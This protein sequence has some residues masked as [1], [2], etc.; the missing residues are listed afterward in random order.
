MPDGVFQCI[1]THPHLKFSCE[2]V[3]T[4]ARNRAPASHITRTN[5]PTRSRDGT[6]NKCLQSAA[7]KRWKRQDTKS[8]AHVCTLH[9]KYSEYFAKNDEY[10]CYRN[11]PAACAIFTTAFDQKTTSLKLK[12]TNVLRHDYKHERAI[13]SD[14]FRESELPSDSSSKLLSTF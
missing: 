3:S 12:D 14:F 11:I 8:K 2:G 1:S 10:E 4:H 6:C 9:S 7:V 13:T 5:E